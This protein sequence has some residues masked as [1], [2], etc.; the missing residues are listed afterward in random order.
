MNHNYR[1]LLYFRLDLSYSPSGPEFPPSGLEFQ[2][3]GLE[4]QPHGPG[5]QPLDLVTGTL[6]DMNINSEPKA[7]K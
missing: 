3:S 1:P 5:S 7:L 6:Y 2:C 4:F